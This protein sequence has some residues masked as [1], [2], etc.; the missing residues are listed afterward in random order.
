MSE[1]IELTGA[2]APKA[3]II[4]QAAA[5]AVDPLLLPDRGT[6]EMAVAT[7]TYVTQLAW[8]YETGPC[9]R[10]IFASTERGLDEVRD[11][12]AIT[13]VAAKI[14]MPLAGIER[15]HAKLGALLAAAAGAKP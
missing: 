15:M 2:R 3:P 7:E 12:D 6:I 10:L 9:V 11:P 13:A 1:I 14:V 4:E 5:A 8:L